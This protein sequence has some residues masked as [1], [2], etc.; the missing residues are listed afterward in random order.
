MHDADGALGLESLT[1]ASS[2]PYLLNTVGDR[3][4]CQP[5]LQLKVHKDQK[6]ES[7]MLSLI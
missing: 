2:Q 7:L 3:P 5:H 6:L 4:A 1:K